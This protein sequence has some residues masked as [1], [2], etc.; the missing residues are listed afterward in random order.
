MRPLLL[1]ETPA[2]TPATTSGGGRGGA[3]ATT[4][5][6][7]T[8]AGNPN[9]PV[10]KALDDVM[11]VQ[12]LSD[13]ADVDKVAYAGPPPVHIAVR[14]APGAGNPLRHYSRLHLH[15]Q[16]NGPHQKAALAGRWRIRDCMAT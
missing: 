4:P 11:W 9:D 12:K 16:E 5:A 2:A 8:P 1:P 6:T 13:I 3:G 15:S 10:L 7:P 14:T